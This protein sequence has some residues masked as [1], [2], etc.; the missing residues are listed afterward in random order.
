MRMLGFSEWTMLGSCDL[1][2]N[3]LHHDGAIKGGWGFLHFVTLSWA[4]CD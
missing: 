4:T 2:V 1:E 3:S